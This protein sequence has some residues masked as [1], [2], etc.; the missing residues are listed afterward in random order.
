MGTPYVLDN[1]TY[2][3]LILYNS[4]ADYTQDPQFTDEKT[5]ALGVQI[6]FLRHMAGQ[7]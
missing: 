1:N 3:I 4:P 6:N 5:S 7:Q 2:I